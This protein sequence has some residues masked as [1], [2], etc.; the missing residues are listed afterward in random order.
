MKDIYIRNNNDVLEK[1]AVIYDEAKLE[2]LKMRVIK[3]C[4]EITK[5]KEECIKSRIP[6]NH[7]Y[8][9]CKDSKILEIVWHDDIKYRK[10]GKQTKMYDHYDWYYEDLYDCSYTRY[11]C[12]PLS[13]FIEMIT[14]G[15]EEFLE[16][17][18]EKDFSLVGKNPTVKEKI[19][20]LQ[21]ELSDVTNNYLLKRKEKLDE[22][23]IKYAILDKEANSIENYSKIGDLIESV[24]CDVS[25]L[26][27]ACNKKEK[28]IK[29][30]LNRLLKIEKDNEKQEDVDKYFNEL[31][32]LVKFELVD[33]LNKND[34]YRI[35]EFFDE[36]V[37]N[38]NVL[39][40]EKIKGNSLV[41][42]R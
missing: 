35:N 8:Y 37:F 3:N 41:K 32:G 22:L 2:D 25:E 20:M 26:E 30:E 40:I 12:Q 19:A 28:A 13:R 17:L 39:D 14:Y 38:S 42:K 4:S 33:T 23:K 24:N 21:Q 15:N 11:S 31:V 36:D 1:Y 18:F 34:I 6:N 9:V 27:K 16:I 7:L 5:A 29:S 10:N